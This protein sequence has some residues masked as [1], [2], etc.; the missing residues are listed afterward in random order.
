MIIQQP[1]TPAE[2]AAPEQW[3]SQLP[4]N[5]NK[6]VFLYPLS[7]QSKYTYRYITVISI[8]KVEVFGTYFDVN[9]LLI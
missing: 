3:V 2:Q 6:A 4:G 7:H 9:L 5:N 8:K 1:G